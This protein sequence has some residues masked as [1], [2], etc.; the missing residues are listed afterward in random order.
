MP[1]YASEPT[2]HAFAQS[3]ACFTEIE[4]R[5]SGGR[6]PRLTHAE[7]EGQMDAR[8]RELLRRLHQDHPD[9]R[10]ARELRRAGDRRDGIT[11]TRAEAGHQR[12]LATVFGRSR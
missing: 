4:E 10:A 1:G 9:L 5:L 6:R 12:Q 2:R 7:M 11:Q 8:G 3:R